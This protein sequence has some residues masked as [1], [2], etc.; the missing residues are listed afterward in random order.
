MCALVIKKVKQ[1][2]ITSVGPQNTVSQIMVKFILKSEMSMAKSH[3]LLFI[4]KILW[5][6]DC[7]VQLKHK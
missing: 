3:D 2:N 5:H 6:Y 4:Y 7:N 1:Y